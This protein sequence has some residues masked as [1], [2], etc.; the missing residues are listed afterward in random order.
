MNKKKTNNC[1]SV[2]ES[3]PSMIGTFGAKIRVLSKEMSILQRIDEKNKERREQTPGVLLIELS[4]KR[5]L[6]Q[7]CGSRVQRAIKD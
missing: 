7:S 6:T 2:L 5:E 3:I 1:K 4:I